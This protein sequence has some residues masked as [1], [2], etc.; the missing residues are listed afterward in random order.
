M[1]IL[2]IV[3]GAHDPGDGLVRK[4]PLPRP[5]RIDP[6]EIPVEIDHTAGAAGRGL[7]A[8]RNREEL[9]DDAMAEITQHTHRLRLADVEVVDE[10][11]LLLLETLARLELAGRRV[12]RLRIGGERRGV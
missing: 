4:Q 6:A 8:G 12:G 10:A 9:L 11:T 1:L 2:T 3:G 7:R 5:A